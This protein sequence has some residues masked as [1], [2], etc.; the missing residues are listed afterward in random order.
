M[1]FVAPSGWGKSTALRSSSRLEEIK[2]SRIRHGSAIELCVDPR[3]L[4]FFDP[5]S[6][7]SIGYPKVTAALV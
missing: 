1:V 2:E 3:Y 4:Q 5:A 7:L 6:G